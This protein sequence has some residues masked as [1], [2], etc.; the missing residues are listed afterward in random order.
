MPLLEP[1]RSARINCP[2]CGHPIN[3]HVPGQKC[4][5]PDL[6]QCYWTPNDVSWYLLF[7]ELTPPSP[8]PQQ[9]RP[10]GAWE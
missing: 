1:P 5:G 10:M 8:V 7:G 6:C 2:N 9:R 3:L 4:T